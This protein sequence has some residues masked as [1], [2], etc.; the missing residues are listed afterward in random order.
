MTRTQYVKTIESELNK[1]NRRIDQKILRGENYFFDSI[2]HKF[3]LKQW[4][5]HQNDGILNRLFPAFF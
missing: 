1:L 2:R 3:L 4:K 5:K